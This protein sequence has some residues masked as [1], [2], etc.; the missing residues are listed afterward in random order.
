M[1]KSIQKKILITGLLFPHLLFCQLDWTWVSGGGASTLYQAPVFGTKGVSA[2]ANT[3]GNNANALTWNDNSGNFWLYGGRNNN[4]VDRGE[5]W[6]YDILSK[7]WTW[8]TGSGSGSGAEAPVYGTK[9]LASPSNDPGA[10]VG[11]VTWTDNA[12]DLWLFGGTNFMLGVSNDLWK[13][14]ISTNMWTWMN[15]PSV[16]TNIT[17]QPVYGTQGVSSSTNRP[18]AVTGALSWK[19]NNGDFWLFGGVGVDNASNYGVF[20]DLWKYSVST[21]Q[22]TWVKGG[23]AVNQIGNYG[24][25]NIASSTNMP[26]GKSFTSGWVSN[27]GDLYLFGGENN[28]AL[29]NDLWKFNI[30]SGNWTWLGGSSLPGQ[31]GVYGTQGTASAQNIPGARSQFYTWKDNNG[32][33]WLFGG[34]DTYWSSH[35]IND[36][37]RY[38]VSTGLWTWLKGSSVALQSG[39]YGTLGVSNPSN[40]PGA[41]SNGAR[42]TDNHGDFWLYSGVTAS[43]SFMPS[44]MWKFTLNIASTVG[45]KEEGISTILIYPNP[46]DN[47]FSIEISSAKDNVSFQLYN[48]IGSIVRYGKLADT[49]NSISVEDLNSGIYFLQIYK[50]GKLMASKK[51][52]IK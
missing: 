5:L 15:G 51:V 24:T 7:Q 39:V 31:S 45:I 35:V 40:T 43:M 9:N 32:D 8:I 38:S 23:A 14:N 49:A 42:W 3:P 34:I 52:I 30:G 16:N 10:R 27:A 33:F 20:N 19:D 11:S 29:L 50:D 26:G 46:T 36:L 25:L 41:R 17:R 4:S 12:G 6:K 21:N 44:D 22:W 2:P 18:P 1:L 13:Y 48:S 28:V 47:Q 37:W